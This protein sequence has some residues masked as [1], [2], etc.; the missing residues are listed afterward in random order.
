MRFAPIKALWFLAMS[1]PALAWGPDAAGAVPLAIAGAL[2]VVTVVLGH[3]V[4][5]HRG[6]IHRAFRTSDAMRRIFAVVFALTGLGGPRT[7][8]VLH[9]VRDH[10]QSRPDAP[11]VWRY[12]HGPALDAWWTLC[13]R[14]VDVDPLAVGVRREDLDDPFLG[15][16][17]RAFFPIQAAQAALLYLLGGWDVLVIGW[18]ARNALVIG[19][20]WFVG[21]VAHTCGTRP[22]RIDGVAEEGR[23][24]W[25]LGVLS[26]G[27]GFHNNH[28]A[29]PACARL[30][31]RWYE[32]DLGWLA[33]LGLERLGLVW[34]VHR[35]ASATDWLRPGARPSPDDTARIPSPAV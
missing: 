14:P 12:D 28:H 4:G 32:L 7:W 21:Y 15:G 26:F 25:L 5:L 20:H 9:A 24:S 13:C 11:A 35:P 33:I 18:C 27:E 34:D 16:V 29:A 6:V 2:I 22:Y 3:T 10:H 1:V 19:G 17:D 8:L 30:G 31:R 23:N